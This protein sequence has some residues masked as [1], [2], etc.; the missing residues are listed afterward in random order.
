VIAERFDRLAAIRGDAVKGL[1]ESAWKANLDD[2]DRD[3][4]LRAIIEA[5]RALVLEE[6][7]SKRKDDRRPQDALAAAEAW[8]ETKSPEALAQAK[9]TAKACTAARNE[10][11]GG[12]HRIPEAARACAWAAGAKDNEHIWE[13]LIAIEQELLAR[14]ALV[15]EYHRL[16]E[17]RRSIL[18][19]LRRV[20]DPKPVEE[21]PASTG[22]VAYS[23]SGR[24]EVGQ[25]LT[26]AKFGD[27]V[28]TAAGD[29]WIDV[30]L[31]DGTTKRLAQKPK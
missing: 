8:L 2:I 7:E 28:V 18:A 5:T 4:L 19:V 17:T 14:I 12:D 9:E 22:P 21:K 24:F 25:K 13:G 15:S 30:T 1:P 23:A 11:F 6:W 16:P 26:H 10:T 20:L 29:K 31:P 27:L 3:L